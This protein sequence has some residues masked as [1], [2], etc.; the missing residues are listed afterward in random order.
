M[1]KL[2][3]TYLIFF[4]F[5]FIVIFPLL[6]VFFLSVSDQY[7]VLAKPLSLPS[8]LKWDNFVKMWTNYNFGRYLLNNIIVT[9]PAVVFG[10]LFSIL[11][12]FAL[13]RMSFFGKQFVY[14][15]LI[16]GLIFPLEVLMISMVQMMNQFALLDTYWAL[17]LP[18]I[19]LGV[20]FGVL[21]LY[22][23]FREIPQ[24]VICSAV[25]DGASSWQLLWK[26]LV[27]LS[28]PAVQASALFMM[29][30]T[31]NGFMLPLV[32]LT[33][34]DMLMTTVGIAY[35]AGTHTTDFPLIMAGVLITIVPIIITYAFLQKSFVRG[36]TSGAV[37]G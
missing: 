29:V 15:M 33:K 6:Y 8:H 2:I 1:I 34:N 23:Y 21:L 27:P 13:A 32:L 9:I 25:I 31:W 36:M 14:F 20:S 7:Q 11:V 10:V 12:S 16:L 19:A 17:I 18:D 24:E 35:F 22:P 5:I 30:W 4:V 28:M 3:L 26:I 37:K